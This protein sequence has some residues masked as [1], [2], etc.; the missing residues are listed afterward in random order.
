MLG[1]IKQTKFITIRARN[2]KHAF[3]IIGTSQ[4]PGLSVCWSVGLLVG[5][6]ASKWTWSYTFYRRTLFHIF[7]ESMIRNRFYKYLFDLWWGYL[8]IRDCLC[9]YLCESFHVCVCIFVCE[10]FCVCVRYFSFT[11]RNYT[12]SEKK[13]FICVL[14]FVC[15]LVSQDDMSQSS[16]NPGFVS[17]TET[18][19]T[20]FG[21]VLFRQWFEFV[22]ICRRSAI[23]SSRARRPGEQVAWIFESRRIWLRIRDSYRQWI[24]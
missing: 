2:L 21:F 4:W 16:T 17:Q 18:E 5:C 6:S 13:S 3:I 12:D 8:C 1:K 23:R 24:R 14:T 20:G 11:Y 15:L 22:D 9:V 19:S 10:C 7:L